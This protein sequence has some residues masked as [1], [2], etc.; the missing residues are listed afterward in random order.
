MNIQNILNN[1]QKRKDKLF[2][3]IYSITENITIDKL[4]KQLFKNV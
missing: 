3:K 4:P 1:I 2:T